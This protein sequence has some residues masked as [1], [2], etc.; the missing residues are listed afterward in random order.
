MWTS[1]LDVVLCFLPSHA[2]SHVHR[3]G[4]LGQEVDGMKGDAVELLE[5]DDGWFREA[6]FGTLAR[7]M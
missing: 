7:H 5:D 2:K 3:Q 4:D 1:P 6:R